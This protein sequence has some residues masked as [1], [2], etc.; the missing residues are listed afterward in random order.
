MDFQIRIKFKMTEGPAAARV[1][2]QMMDLLNTDLEKI[3]EL[4]IAKI[5]EQVI[6]DLSKEAT[7]LFAKEPVMLD[8]TGDFIIVGD[9][10]GYLPDLLRIIQKFGDSKYIFLGDTVDRGQFSIETI[11]LIAAMK[12]LRP[13]EV[14]LI[15]GNHEFE[16]VCSCC[17]FLD[18]VRTLYGN[19]GPFTSIVTMF[20]QLPLAARVNNRLLCLHGGIGPKFQTL[21]QLKSVVR[22]LKQLYGGIADCIVW[23]DPNDSVVQF[24]ENEA[25]GNGFLF[26]TEA[27]SEFLKRNNLKQIIRGHEPVNEGVAYALDNQVITVFSAS[28]Y[29]NFK[30]N[31]SGVLVVREDGSEE[32]VLFPALGV[33]TRMKKAVAEEPRRRTSSVRPR[34]PRVLNP[35]LSPLVPRRSS[36]HVIGYIL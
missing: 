33:I 19:S 36:N 21:D 25:R 10:H 9:V 29:C 12:I 11:C 28:N 16:S 23:S 22:P 14:F 13:T 1:Y 32:A 4:C 31:K 20:H 34:I 27:V 7:D 2:K 30:G 24:R 3:S 18:E 17:G 8:L 35:T 5:D 15:R 6:T 26:G